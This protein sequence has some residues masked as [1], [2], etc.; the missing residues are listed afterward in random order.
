MKFAILE[1]DHRRQQLMKGI[2]AELNHECII[3]DNAPGM[4]E[5][6]K[7]NIA[8]VG[9]LSL[10]HDLGPNRELDGKSFDPGTGRDVV[11]FLATLKP[12]APVVI[13]TSK[14]YAYPGMVF[15]LEDSGWI[16]KRVVPISDLNW[17]E[18][19]WRNSVLEL[20]KT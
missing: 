8:N 2:I 12:S 15:T 5:W 18:S 13:H 1:D 11:D 7:K 20:L 14:I 16:V 6:L 10:D 3:F 19:S 17:I 4:I 9:L